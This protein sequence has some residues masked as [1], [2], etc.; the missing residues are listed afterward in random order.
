MTRKTK[1]PT[2]KTTWELRTYDVWGNPRD[3][4]E[5]NDSRNHGEI[6]LV[7]DVHKHNEGTTAEF[8]GAYPSDKQIR[9]AFGVRCRLQLNGDDL[10]IT[11]DRERDLYPIGE[12]T[13]T[14]HESLS[15]I[16]A[17]AEAK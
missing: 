17:L 13:C 4:Y 2:V 14:S 8:I 10:H 6:E 3:G 1:A 9:A 15:P 11:V 16:R 12:L 7:L 5:V